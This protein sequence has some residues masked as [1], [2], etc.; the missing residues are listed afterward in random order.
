MKVQYIY[1]ADN[2]VIRPTF[3]GVHVI[4]T[5]VQKLLLTTLDSK[6][7][8]VLSQLVKKQQN[9]SVHILLNSKNGKQLN[10]SLICDYRLSDFKPKYKQIPF[11]ESKIHFIKRIVNTA[12]KY[13]KQIQDFEVTKLKW[14]YPVLSEWVNKIYL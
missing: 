14:K 2:S 10:A 13:K 7:I 6:Q 8:E 4:D 12:E 3:N 9:N 11:F 1:R 5:D